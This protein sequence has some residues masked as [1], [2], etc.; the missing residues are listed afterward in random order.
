MNMNKQILTDEQMRFLHTLD[1]MGVLNTSIEAIVDNIPSDE[2]KHIEHD[3]P[4][5]R[6]KLYQDQYRKTDSGR[7]ARRL[8]QKKYIKKKKVAP[9]IKKK[10]KKKIILGVNNEIN[11]YEVYRNTT[12]PYCG[13]II[14]GNCMAMKKNYGL[15]TQCKNKQKSEGEYCSVC[16]ESAKNNSTEKP[17]YGDIRERDNLIK[18][19]LL[20]GSIVNYGNIVEK[21]E[22]NKKKCIEEANK[23]GWKIA[24][25]QW[26]IKKTRRGRPKS[27]KVNI[28]AVDD[29]EKDEYEISGV[30]E[31]DIIAHLMSICD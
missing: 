31:D 17:K 2:A 7:E 6:G 30:G 3:A 24:D 11:E 15:Y 16:F 18:N 26:E 12:L 1:K 8:A 4:E 10:R 5:N 14:K 25:S 13:K 23:L 21:L 22:L 9:V 20:N 29:S 27:I 19:N 28:V